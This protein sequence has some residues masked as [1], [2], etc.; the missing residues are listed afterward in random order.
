MPG[1]LIELDLRGKTAVVVGLGRVGRRKA[2]DLVEAGGRVVSIDPDAAPELEAAGLIVRRQPYRTEHLDGAALVIAAAPPEVNR[3]VVADARAAGI[4]MNA[5]SE[6][7]EGDYR[8]PAVW[9]DGPLAV[10]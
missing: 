8:V 9:R 6:P 4:W 5:A 2:G 10:A 7:D 3:A 1:Y